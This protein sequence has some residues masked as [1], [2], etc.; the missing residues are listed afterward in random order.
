MPPPA[1]EPV[2][3]PPRPSDPSE[4]EA[5]RA[6]NQLHLDAANKKTAED[7]AN[8]DR[9]DENLRR[10]QEQKA[11]IAE[12]ERKYESDYAAYLRETEA[13]AAAQAKWEADRAQ[14]ERDKAACL[15][16]DHSKCLRPQK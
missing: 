9:Y 16:G 15:D 13:A 4:I 2:V 10:Q 12:Q 6:L 14:W 3:K 8:F 11:L 7:Q 1:P 5:L